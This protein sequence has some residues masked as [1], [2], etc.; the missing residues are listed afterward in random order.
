MVVALRSD[1]RDEAAKR[2][3]DYSLFFGRE[4]SGSVD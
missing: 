2:I 4:L 1:D 3:S